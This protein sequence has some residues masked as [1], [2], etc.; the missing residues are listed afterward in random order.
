MHEVHLWTIGLDHP[1]ETWLPMLECLSPDEETRAARFRFESDRHRFVAARIALR[2]I[3]GSHLGVPPR[4]IVLTY[5]PSGKPALASDMAVGIEFNLSHCQG[6]ALIV[7]ASG[8]RLGVDLEFVHPGA[9]EEPLAERFFSAPEVTALRALPHDLQDEAFFA[10]WTRKEAYLK[11]RGDGLSIPL[12]SFT[13]SL[14][15]GE[16]AALLACTGAKDE[17]LAWSFRSFTPAPGFL[18]ALAVEGEGWRLRRR[19]WSPR[20]RVHEDEPTFS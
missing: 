8:R 2:E 13:V 15:P 10:C 19:R 3:L 4:E 1:W 5:R 20:A 9:A 18:A 12:D 16:P 6:L 11:A 14:A 17:I 7:V